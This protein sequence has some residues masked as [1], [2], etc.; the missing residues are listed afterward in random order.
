MFGFPKS[1]TGHLFDDAKV[2]VAL[3]VGNAPQKG[4]AEHIDPSGEAPFTVRE[5]GRAIEEQGLADFETVLF[6][7][8]G[9][10]GD[11]RIIPRV[12]AFG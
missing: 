11:A 12:R 3:G 7:K 6:K 1:G 10:F 4:F 2:I 5:F 9:I 8:S